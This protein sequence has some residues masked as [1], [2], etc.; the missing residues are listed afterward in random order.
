[1]GKKK[2]NE[3]ETEKES[4]DINVLKNICELLKEK[5]KGYS[6]LVKAFTIMNDKLD[7]NIEVNMMVCEQADLT[8]EK[9]VNME[10]TLAMNNQILNEIRE[11]CEGDKKDTNNE[12]YKMMEEIND[13][14]WNINDKV[15]KNNQ[16][17]DDNFREKT[18]I[19]K[20]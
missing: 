14:C 18:K 10:R 16:M 20:I 8:N 13:K 3:P 11:T 5:V 9:I 1:M 12:N 7:R 4:E 6:D 19:P 17:L 2:N 15:N